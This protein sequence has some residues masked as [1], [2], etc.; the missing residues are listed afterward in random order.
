MLNLKEKIEQ[1]ENLEIGN[2]SK[3]LIL[4]KE[5][6]GQS[7]FY[8]IVK[9]GTSKGTGIEKFCDKMNID[10][11]DCIA[12]GDNKNDLSMFEKVGMSVAMG[13]ATDYIKSKANF[14]TE[15]NDENGVA[16][17]L[18]MMIKEW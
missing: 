9:R 3:A 7:Y 4:K 10:L 18:N 12:I 13:N 1:F 5:T 15:T 11:V 8:D 17:F 6:P 16:N 2:Y 14:I